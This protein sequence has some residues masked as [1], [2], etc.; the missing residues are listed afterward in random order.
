MGEGT[1]NGRTRHE[2]RVIDYDEEVMYH[3]AKS[4]ILGT[5]KKP[6]IGF[7]DVIK[8]HFK[9]KAPFIIKTIEKWINHKDYTDAFKSKMKP[10]FE[11]IKKEFA[12]L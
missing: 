4:A 7:E 3:N 2:R 1:V 5:L 9:I 6:Y 8:T 10:V 12:K 11:E